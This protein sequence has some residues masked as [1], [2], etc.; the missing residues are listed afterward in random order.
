MKDPQLIL[1]IVLAGATVVYTVINAL[2]LWESKKVRKQKNTPLL[3]AYLDICDY[4]LRV[5][6]RNIGEG[7]AKDVKIKVLKDYNQWGREEKPLS[8]DIMIK[9]G[10]DIFPPQFEQI[11]QLDRAI[12]IESGQIADKEIEIEVEYKS[13]TGNKPIMRKY[14]LSFNRI[15][16][17]EDSKTLGF[18][19]RRIKEQNGILAKINE[20]L[21]KHS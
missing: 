14:C 13:L 10:V 18:I 4:E 9:N 11:V 21:L 1:S 6:I 5:C 8:E 2:M 19:S 7:C 20:T 3:I 12:K 16:G 17:N 15:G